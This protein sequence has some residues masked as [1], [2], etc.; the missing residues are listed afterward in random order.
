MTPNVM[1]FKY[2]YVLYPVYILDYSLIG[3]IVDQ[4]T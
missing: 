1:V 4:L 2:V 3:A